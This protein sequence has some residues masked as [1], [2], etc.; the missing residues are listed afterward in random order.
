MMCDKFLFR[1]FVVPCNYL[2]FL[3]HLKA[4]KDSKFELLDFN[5][6]LSVNETYKNRIENLDFFVNL[7]F[8]EDVV[9]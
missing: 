2:K 5:N 7:S 3:N 4:Y 8:L 6:E 1:L 9:V